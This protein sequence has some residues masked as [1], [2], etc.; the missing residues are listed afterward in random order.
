[1]LEILIAYLVTLASKLTILSGAVQSI[2]G[3]FAMIIAS[4][5]A[6][7]LSLSGV[8]AWVST[9]L[10]I[11]SQPGRYK[12]LHKYINILGGNVGNAA[13]SLSKIGKEG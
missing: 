4:F 7:L 6:I 8:L 13:N 12:T 3:S 1:M 2:A 9:I 10:P 11:P 5:G